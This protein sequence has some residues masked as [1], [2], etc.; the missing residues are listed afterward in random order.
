MKIKR[1]YV[2][3]VRIDA[4]NFSSL[5]EFV[6]EAIEK[7]RKTYIVLTGA[8]GIVEMQ[9]DKQL[10]RINNQAGLVTPDGMPEV[11][12]GKLKG[13]KNIQKL[14]ASN[15]MQKIFCESE[16]TGYRH[17]M[18]GG[19]EGVAQILAKVLKIQYPKISIVGTYSPPFRPLTID[20]EIKISKQINASGANIVWCGLGCPKQEKWM[21]KFRPHLDAPILIGV[22]AGF[23]FLSGEKPLAPKFIQYSG[24]EWLYRLASDPKRLWKRYFRVV[25]KFIY[26]V[27][28]ELTGIKKFR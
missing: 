2:L 15:I 23:D 10:L 6:K 13:Y 24:F 20:E 17:F 11:W 4:V 18:Y 25:P 7:K 27:F 12:L 1:F 16:H 22:G 8:H 26:L 14:C 21:S 3:G 5:L 28:L 9:K 19:N